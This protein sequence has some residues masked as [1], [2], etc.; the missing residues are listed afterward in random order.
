MRQQLVLTGQCRC[1]HLR[2]HETRFEAWRTGEKRRQSL[3][4]IGMHQPVGAPLADYREI[5]ADDRQQITGHA[6]GLPVK[7][8]AT[9]QFARLEHERIVRGRIQL[10]LDDT[11]GK[12]QRV[13]GGTVHLR[14]AS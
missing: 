7:I 12:L 5:R 6:D 8:A 3:I 1:G 4:E 10:A 11:L 2:H 14:Y 9:E 13:V